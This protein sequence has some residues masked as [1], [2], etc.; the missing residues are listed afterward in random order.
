M[1]I[2]NAELIAAETTRS[3]WKM[4]WLV[5]AATWFIK[6][7]GSL[8]FIA[9]PIYAATQKRYLRS[10]V[11]TAISL[12]TLALVWEP[13]SLDAS[14]FVQIETRMTWLAVIV[15]ICAPFLFIASRR[16]ESKIG[17]EG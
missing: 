17:H 10:L 1:Q 8:F 12:T 11:I 13:I 15:L 16:I 7:I 6:V 4:V 14:G 2:T 5:V 3:N 9:L